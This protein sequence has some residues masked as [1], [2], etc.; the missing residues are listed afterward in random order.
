MGRPESSSSTLTF[1]IN[2]HELGEDEALR[3]AYEDHGKWS[4]ASSSAMR[5]LS[6]HYQWEDHPSVSAEDMPPPISNRP[7]HFNTSESTDLDDAIDIIHFNALYG[8]KKMKEE[9]VD[10]DWETKL[11]AEIN[12]IVKESDEPYMTKPSSL[13]S[14]ETISFEQSNSTSI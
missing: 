12:R 1:L 2:L 14:E 4:E 10:P 7:D 8:R 3:I 13:S 11:Q 5:A 6:H 9:V